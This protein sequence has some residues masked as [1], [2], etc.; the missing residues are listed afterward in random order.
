MNELEIERIVINAKH[1]LKKRMRKMDEELIKYNITGSHAPFILL[2][3]ENKEGLTMTELSKKTRVDKALTSR[4][5]KDLMDKN[6]IIK[7]TEKNRNSK[8]SLSKKG[9]KIALNICTYLKKERLNILE[10]FNKEEIKEIK[11]CIELVMN[12]LEESE[13]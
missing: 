8:I 9:E 3:S 11:K 12:K 1:V 2:L 6:Y 5:I 13:G 7:N 4:V 10:I